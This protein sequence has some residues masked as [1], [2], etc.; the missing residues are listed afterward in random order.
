MDRYSSHDAISNAGDKVRQ[1]TE[2]KWWI[3][4]I[5]IHETSKE[6]LQLE[7]SEINIIGI[8]VKRVV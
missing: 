2:R 8:A 7:Q 1:G 3:S 5:V 4:V 6:I